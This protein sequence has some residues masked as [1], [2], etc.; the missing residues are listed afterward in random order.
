[1]IDEIHKQ[2]DTIIVGRLKLKPVEDSDIK[3][4]EIWLNTEHVLKWYH[5]AS[6]W[7]NEIK[8]RNGQFSFL[9]HFI[10]LNKSEP[11]GFCQYYDCFYAK[12]D[13]YCVDNTN[14]I[15]SIDYFIGEKE[16]LRKGYGKEIV[17][18]LVN[19][20][21]K[22]SNKIDIVVQ[23][24]IENIASCKALLSNGFTYDENKK[25]FILRRKII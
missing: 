12:E 21:W 9:N 14:E 15:F 22:L 13:W 7:L 20:I 1:M 6:E 11:I 16:Y 18:L 10:V 19:E 23:P 17:R 3:Q 8:E 5:D 25:Y 24:E 4:L 2:N